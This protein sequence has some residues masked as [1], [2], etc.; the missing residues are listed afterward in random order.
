MPEE[1]ILF[2]ATALPKARGGV[3]RYVEGLLG[4]L[5]AAGARVT[6]VCQS[7]DA[8][9][10]RESFP[11][12]ALV[13]LPRACQSRAARFLWEQSGLPLLA[14]RIGATVVHSPHYTMPL[15][16]SFRRV[17]TIHDATFFSDPQVHSRLKGAFFRFWTKRA[18]NG[19]DAVVV[20]SAAT[21]RELSNYL[22]G[23][24]AQVLV[25]H[26]GVDTSIFHTPSAAE[27]ST[28]RASIGLG[29]EPYIAFLGTLEPRKNIPALIRAMALVA[30]RHPAPV[31]VL[32]GGAG[33]DTAI[34]AEVTAAQG[35]V[36]IIQP[37][38][39]PIDALPSF[40]HGALAVV[41]PSLGEGFGLPVLEA[42][43]SGAL[44]ITTR[45]LALPEVGGDAVLYTE[46]DDVSI[47]AAIVRV[48]EHPEDS[49]S[50]RDEALHRSLSFTWVRS[51]RIH[52]AA[53]VGHEST[54]VQG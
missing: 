26:H 19:A 30:T 38:Y 3:G 45:R 16:G 50:L 36:R 47:A 51:A 44:V 31:L 21:A 27:R 6:I 25:A 42:M 46:I 5:T 12:F 41:Y 28:A 34:A 22:P 18:V 24:P 17:V 23:F 53:Y 20:P 39:L 33:W 37:G 40:L 14:R 35:T 11:E 1:S 43:A 8:A 7:R 10:F 54:V 15:V 2:D 29:E 49:A 52:L 9:F 32:A 48:I 4:G 13:E